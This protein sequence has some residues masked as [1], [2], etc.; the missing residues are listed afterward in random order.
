M[1]RAAMPTAE[2]QR[3]AIYL[4][5]WYKGTIPDAAGE[6]EAYKRTLRLGWKKEG[7]LAVAQVRINTKRP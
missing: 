2:V 5:Y 3:Y 7:D 1:A 6:Q 4:L